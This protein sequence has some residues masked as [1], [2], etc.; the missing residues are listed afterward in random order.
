[1]VKI[2]ILVPAR[3][4]KYLDKTIDDILKHK[5][6]DTEILVG[7]DGWTK[8][9]RMR[10]LP[11]VE[12]IWKDKSIGQRAI[13]NELARLSEADYVMKIDA[14]VSFSQGFDRIMLEDIDDRTILAPRLMPLDAEKWEIPL[15]TPASSYAFDTNLVFQYHPKGENSELL[16]ETMC[17]QGSAWMITRENYWKWNICDESLGSWGGQA[18]E[19]GIKA[20]LNGGRCATAK[21]VYYAHMFREKESQFPYQR[22]KE[23][24]R[25]TLNELRKRYLN[26]KIAGLIEKFNYPCDWNKERV[27]QLASLRTPL[28]E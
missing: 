9:Y 2:S 16:N 13:T 4:E 3:D 7:L 6:S 15:I 8:D 17:L 19:L 5:E 12:Y 18:A 21:K 26:K 20:W 14:H 11:N 22:N 1:M 10:N 27:A 25:A 24:I 28:C 23:H